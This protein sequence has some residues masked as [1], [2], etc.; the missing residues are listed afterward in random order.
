MALVPDT[1][2]SVGNEQ[3]I[4]NALREPGDMFLYRLVQNANGRPTDLTHGG[5]T[6]GF[7]YIAPDG[8]TWLAELKQIM[9]LPEKS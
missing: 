5:G 2:G 4:A 9:P 8:A 1:A 3:M 6:S 7:A